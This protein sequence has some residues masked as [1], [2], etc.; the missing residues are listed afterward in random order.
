MYRAS[1]LQRLR[2]EIVAFG[3][4]LGADQQ[5]LRRLDAKRLEGYLKKEESERKSET[6]VRWREYVCSLSSRVARFAWSMG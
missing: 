4:K 6:V 3:E 2:Q 1:L 5:E